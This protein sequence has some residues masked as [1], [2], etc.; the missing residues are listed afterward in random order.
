MRPRSPTGLENIDYL[1]SLGIVSDVPQSVNDLVQFQ[2]MVENST[3][4][5]RER[6]NQKVRAI[7]REH[8]PAALPDDVRTELGRIIEQAK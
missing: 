1:M 7:L 8:E 2:Q 4:P 6:L 3:K 5:L